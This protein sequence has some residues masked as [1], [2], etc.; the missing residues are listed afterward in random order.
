MRKIDTS[1]NSATH[2]LQSGKQ[3][4]SDLEVEATYRIPAKTLR[5]MRIL[6][7]GPRYRKFNA[8]VR[9]QIC[10]VETWIESLPTGGEGVPASALKGAR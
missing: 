1:I 6:G 7:R 3:F 4:V 9:Y 5:N 10:D 2:A 8:A